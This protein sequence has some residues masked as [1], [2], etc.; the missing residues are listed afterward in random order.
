MRKGKNMKNKFF[1]L[2]CAGSI[3]LT[4]GMIT[5]CSALEPAPTQPQTSEDVLS[6][7]AKAVKEIAEEFAEA[8]FRGDKD[9]IQS[10]LTTPYE[11]DIEVYTDTG[12]ID[13]LTIKGLTEIGKEEIGSSKVISIEY[14]NSENEDTFQYLT[15]E[16]MKQEDGWK[17]QFYGIGQ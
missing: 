10:H 8:Y 2:I 6:A 12:A 3:I 15:L 14:K 1:I 13:N 4:L 16:F 17:I 5:G 7:D 9:S 11:W